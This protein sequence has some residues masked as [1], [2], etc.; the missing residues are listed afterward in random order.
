VRRRQPARGRARRIVVGAVGASGVAGVLV[1]VVAR[2]REEF[3]TALHSAPAGILVAAAALQLVAL[4]TRTAAWWI[5]V[6]AAGGM[7]DR[8]PLFRAASM[9]YLGSQLNSQLG[10]AARIV[11]LR[12]AAPE[13]VP[14]V[15]ALIAAELRSCWSGAAS[16][17]WP[18]VT[19]I[20]PLGLPWWAPLALLAAALIVGRTLYGQ[21]G[22]HDRGFWTGVAVLR[23]VSG[24]TQMV[25]L[26]LVAVFA[27]SR[28][29][30]SCCTPS[31]STR[32]CPTRPP[33]SSRWSR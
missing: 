13:T 12:R 32:R 31:A 3:V 2:H 6:R 18:S 29:T 28:A 16:P 5:G 26:L 14:R 20:A 19:L 22:R 24:R 23:G 7:V 10:A 21:C 33:C 30:G 17:R 27:R 15:P 8:R 11:A 1:A 25:L 9:G 4:V